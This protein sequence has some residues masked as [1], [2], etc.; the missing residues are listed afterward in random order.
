M[1]YSRLVELSHHTPMN[2]LRTSVEG[3]INALLDKEVD[4]L[5]S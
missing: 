2:L 4:K 5:M 1:I 3:S